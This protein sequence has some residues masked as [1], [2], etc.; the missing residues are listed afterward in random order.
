MTKGFHTLFMNTPGF[1]QFGIERIGTLGADSRIFQ[2]DNGAAEFLFQLPR[3]GIALTMARLPIFGWGRPEAMAEKITQAET[4]DEAKDSNE[5]RIHR[6]NLRG[7][8][9]EHQPYPS[10]FPMRVSGFDV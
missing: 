4:E 5:S 1:A 3:F 9:K 2:I 7:T 8:H 6:F 10:A